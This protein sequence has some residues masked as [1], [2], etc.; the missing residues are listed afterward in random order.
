MA[1]QPRHPLVHRQGVALL[2]SCRVREGR[3]LAAGRGYRDCEARL[4][5]ELGVQPD[6]PLR[7]VVEPSLGAAA[8]RSRP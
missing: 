6:E 3:V 1:P 5:R 4:E 2:L 7:A 8:S